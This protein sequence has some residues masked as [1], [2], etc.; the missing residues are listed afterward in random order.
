MSTSKAAVALVCDLDGVIRHYDTAAQAAVELRY[1]LPGGAIRDVCFSSPLLSDAISGRV[2]D[3]QW[4]EAAAQTLTALDGEAAAEALREW[5]DLPVAL[6]AD[7]LELIAEVIEQH[8]VIL[9]TNATDRL[10]DD[11]VR[12]GIEDV[13]DAIVNT[14]VVG[15]SKPGRAAVQA[16]S[17]AVARVLD[18]PA[19]PERIAFVDDTRGHVMAA[20][21][22][23]WQGHLYLDAPSL[24]NFLHDCRLLRRA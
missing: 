11:L 22:L 20:Q 2:S 18:G 10:A 1:G 17:A 16:A 21:A 7:V 4:R 6:A 12:L 13:F 9:L 3:R 24:R 23:G 8:P 19:L 14:S 5:S 15:T